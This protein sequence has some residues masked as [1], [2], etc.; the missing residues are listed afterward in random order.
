MWINI[1]RSHGLTLDLCKV[2]CT[3]QQPRSVGSLAAHFRL[4]PPRKRLRCDATWVVNSTNYTNNSQISVVLPMGT[5]RNSQYLCALLVSSVKQSCLVFFPPSHTKW[6]KFRPHHLTDTI[7]H[8]H[9]F[10][11]VR[12]IDFRIANQM[13][14]PGFILPSGLCLRNFLVAI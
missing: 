14:F 11:A 4:Q 7:A 6:A 1:F 10:I 5:H 12:L 13:S 2:V 3:Q 9:E 8:T